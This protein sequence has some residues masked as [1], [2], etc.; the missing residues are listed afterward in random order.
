[1]PVS[2]V[3]SSISTYKKQFVK[4]QEVDNTLRLLTATIEGMK[5]WSQYSTTLPL[6][7]EI[8]G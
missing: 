6:L 5:Y 1:M 3:K 4:K 8:I 2:L 7:F